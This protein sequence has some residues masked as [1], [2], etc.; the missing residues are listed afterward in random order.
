MNRD[1]LNIISFGPEMLRGSGWLCYWKP[2]SH[3]S[4]DLEQQTVVITPPHQL[5]ATG[6]SHGP[7]QIDRWSL[8]QGHDRR[9]QPD[10]QERVKN[11]W[12]TSA[13]KRVGFVPSE[14]W[15]LASRQCQLDES[16]ISQDER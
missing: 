12:E 16:F 3:V 10:A 7:H 13:E 8:R 5:Q 15:L 9:H 14:G 11:G 1:A 6:C 2:V 4:L